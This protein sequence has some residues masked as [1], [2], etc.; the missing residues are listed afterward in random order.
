MV[1]RQFLWTQST[2]VSITPYKIIDE[3]L[4]FRIPKRFCK[5]INTIEVYI[6]KAPKLLIK[7]LTKKALDLYSRAFNSMLNST[8][9]HFGM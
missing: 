5:K 2:I 1:I 9:S 8:Y 4:K 7:V 6:S 3:P